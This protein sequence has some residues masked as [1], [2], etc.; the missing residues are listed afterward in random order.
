MKVDQTRRSASPRRTIQRLGDTLLGAYTAG[1]I[2]RVRMGAQTITGEQGRLDWLGVFCS[3]GCAVHCAA[4][5][6]LV[7][8]LPSLTSLRWLADPL[9]HQLVAVFCGILVARAIVPGYRMHRDGRVVSLAGV[10]LGLLFIAA[11]ILPGTC[12]S[13]ATESHN[14][15]SSVDRSHKIVLVSSKT[16]NN[17]V[18]STTHGRFDQLDEQHIVNTATCEI[19]DCSHARTISRP[20]LTAV[21]LEG[22]LGKTS[23]QTLILAQPYLSPV[24]GLFLIVAH[25]LNIRLRCCSRSACRK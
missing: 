21:E 13:D 20:L 7:A 2:I 4:M 1:K 15:P 24:G 25:V 3:F 8:T 23:A 19:G 17:F 14:S 16:A 6:I 10:G 5:P 11:F 12:C 18:A 22:Q 9:F